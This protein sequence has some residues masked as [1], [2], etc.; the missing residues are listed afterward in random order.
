[1]LD[2]ECWTNKSDVHGYEGT[3]YNVTSLNQC[4]AACVINVSCTAIDWE[5]NNPTGKYCWLLWSTVTLDT[6]DTGVIV[7][8]EL[9]RPCL[10]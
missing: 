2:A 4:Q 1:V 3:P 8:Y 6:L 10:G 5:P 7:H 9:S